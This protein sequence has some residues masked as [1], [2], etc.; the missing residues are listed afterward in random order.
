M[1]T[2]YKMNKKKLKNFIV[3]LFI[4]FSYLRVKIINHIPF[5]SNLWKKKIIFTKNKI[6][7][8]KKIVL[9]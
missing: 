8:T 1:I 2:Y 7:F 5:A 4:N 6:N 3:I 9:L